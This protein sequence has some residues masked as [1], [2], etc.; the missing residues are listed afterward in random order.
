MFQ[1]SLS[2]LK[3]LKGHVVVTQ[4][5]HSRSVTTSEQAFRDASR[6]FAALEL[7]RGLTL[8]LLL[9]VIEDIRGKRIRIRTT[10]KLVGTSICGLWL[11][12]EKVEWVFHPPTP[13]ELQRQQFILHELAHMVL[14]HDTTP[15]AGTVLRSGMRGLSPEIVRRALMRTEFRTLEEATAEY[16][17]DLMAGAL[18]AGPGEPG[19]F[20]EVFG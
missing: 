1:T 10:E 8:S 14:G 13:W 6:A 4:A 19:A 12:G 11:P 3:L 5:L 15:G 20:E 9:S 2:P 16:L 7:P 17:A 18:R